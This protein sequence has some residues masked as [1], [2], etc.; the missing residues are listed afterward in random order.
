MGDDMSQ[1]APDPGRGRNAGG[2]VSDR[3][4]DP[5]QATTARAGG[6]ASGRAAPS[7]QTSLVTDLGTTRIAD[8]VVAKIAGLAA[9]D[10]PGVYSLGTGMARRVGQLRSLVPGSSDADAAGQGVTVQVGEREA[11]VDLDLVTWYGQSI[12]DIGDAVRRH[13]IGQVQSMTGLRV[14]EVNIQIDD[15]HVESQ[16]DTPEQAPQ[17]QTTSR[18]Q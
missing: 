18:V 17:Q 16:D 13:V 1:N 6:G 3:T 5:G 12:A 8:A 7:G 9:R 2:G 10:I 11:A 4:T 15:I 14:V